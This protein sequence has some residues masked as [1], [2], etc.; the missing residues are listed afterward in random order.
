ML[1]FK[2]YFQNRR[3]FIGLIILLVLV[4]AIPLGIYLVR[5]TQIFA[6]KADV[7]GSI[8]L[9]EGACVETVNGEKVLTCKNVPLRL[10]SPF[11]DASSS[12][13]PAG[14]SAASVSPSPASVSPSPLGSSSLAACS[15][16]PPGAVAGSGFVW[17]A[18]CQQAC[19]PN[20]HSPTGHPEIKLSDDC[21]AEDWC[22]QFIEGNRCLQFQT[23]N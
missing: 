11:E 1:G 21:A 12:A 17:K 5:N 10:I 23:V 13:T 3:N 7:T 20:G 15:D 19:V 8:A 6:P 9:A 2:S 14:S 22:Y 16:N 4:F 18:M